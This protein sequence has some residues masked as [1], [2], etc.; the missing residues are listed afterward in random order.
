MVQF[1]DG[2]DTPVGV[3][4]GTQFVFKVVDI[5]VV[6]QMQTP[7]VPLFRKT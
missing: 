2:V 3:Q 1:W 4:R 7:M 5:S 6:A